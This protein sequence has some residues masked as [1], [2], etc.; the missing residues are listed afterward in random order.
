[1]QEY[2]VW[3]ANGWGKN[4]LGLLVFFNDNGFKHADLG[5]RFF[6]MIGGIH[7]FLKEIGR[8]F[9]ICCRFQK[10]IMIVKLII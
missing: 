2:V 1:V 8:L 4:P 9:S 5:G 7:S 10:I 3:F 6:R